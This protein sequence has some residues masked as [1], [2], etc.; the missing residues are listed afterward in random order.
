MATT[1]YEYL[2]NNK[3]K[4]LHRF[5][6]PSQLWFSISRSHSDRQ[7]NND[8]DFRLTLLKK[9]W[10]NGNGWFLPLRLRRIDGHRTL[11]TNRRVSGVCHAKVSIGL[12]LSLYLFYTHTQRHANTQYWKHFS[13]AQNALTQKIATSARL[14]V[15]TVGWFFF[16]QV[17]VNELN[18]YKIRPL[19]IAST[20]MKR[21]NIIWSRKNEPDGIVFFIAILI[22]FIHLHH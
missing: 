1:K 12:S 8:E 16:L 3:I 21:F 13:F 15:Y 6:S 4:W 22:L 19:R 2:N 18:R 17:I 5:F 20:N 10:K 14:H 7:C 9:K 11:H